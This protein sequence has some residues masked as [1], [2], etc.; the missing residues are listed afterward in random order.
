MMEKHGNITIDF[1]SYGGN[2]V[3][4]KIPFHMKTRDLINELSSIYGYSELQDE[5]QLQSFK[6]LLSNK[7]ISNKETLLD[8]NIKNGEILL[9]IK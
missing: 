1:S 9:I 5:L 6:A 7:F 2:R 8:A 3:D 4:L